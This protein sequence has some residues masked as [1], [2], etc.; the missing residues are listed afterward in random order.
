MNLK[1]FLFFLKENNL[2]FLFKRFITE[3]TNLNLGDIRRIWD[4]TKN[5]KLYFNLQA[6]IGYN[7]LYR[8]IHPN[9]R[10][11]WRDVLVEFVSI[12][13]MFP[14]VKLVNSL[15]KIKG[16]MYYL[17][18]KNVILRI[19]EMIKR[20]HASNTWW[21]VKYCVISKSLIA[22]NKC[23]HLSKRGGYLSTIEGCTPQ[24]IQQGVEL[25]TREEFIKS[26]NLISEPLFK[27]LNEKLKQ[28]EVCFSE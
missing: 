17:P 1:L 28:A 4:N 5:N 27:K 15:D 26:L 7:N 25:K 13:S 21:E 6:L 19:D 14:I 2:F 9:S 8:R 16:K 22:S 12:Q 18:K 24:Y 23:I 11:T 3:V 20:G 10:I